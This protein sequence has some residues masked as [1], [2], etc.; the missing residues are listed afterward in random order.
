MNSNKGKTATLIFS[1]QEMQDYPNSIVKIQE[2]P[3]ENVKCFILFGSKTHNIG[4]ESVEAAINQRIALSMKRYAML[5]QQLQNRSIPLKLRVIFLD[6]LVR[7]T[8]LYSVEAMTLNNHQVHRLESVYVMFLR[9]MVRNG[10]QKL[11]DSHQLVISNRKIHQITK[12]QEIEI[13][14]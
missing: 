7:S 9:R 8:L 13:Y 10:L 1:P 6:A 5:S 11:K 12:M 2:I 14:V 3:I 4:S